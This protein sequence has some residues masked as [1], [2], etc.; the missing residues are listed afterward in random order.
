VTQSLKQHL[1]KASLIIGH[2]DSESENAD[3]DNSEDDLQSSA[4]PTTASFQTDCLDSLAAN[5]NLLMDM[6]PTLEQT[7]RQNNYVSDARFHKAQQPISAGTI[8]DIYSRIIRDRFPLVER[9]LVD[10]LGEANERRHVRLRSIKP[11]DT[12][13]DPGLSRFPK[14]FRHS[15]SRTKDSALGSSLPVS[16]EIGPSAPSHSSFVSSNGAGVKAYC[17]VP[18]LP[19][20]ANYG[21]TFLCSF[22]K[23]LISRINTRIDWK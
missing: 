7:Y 22:C 4:S 9:S 2:Q 1:E 19:K 3:S 12:S 17:R 14:S 18:E 11:E 6:C 21:E 23:K 5:V 16:S 10:R 8:A 13:F 15:A 20:G